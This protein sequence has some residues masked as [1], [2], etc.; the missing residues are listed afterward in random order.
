M[1]NS[2]HF[3]RVG[4]LVF[5]LDM[6]DFSE[7]RHLSPFAVPECPPDVSAV[8][9]LTDELT[10]PT[11]AEELSRTPTKSV[12]LTEEGKVTVLRGIGDEKP[13]LIARETASRRGST[14][15]IRIISTAGSRSS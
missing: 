12:F 2:K 14:P 5:S 15:P 7:S 10:V 4:G 8:L 13:I 1:Q 11:G 9:E 6:P 3:Y